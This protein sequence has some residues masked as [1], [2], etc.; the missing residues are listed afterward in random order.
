MP[1]QIICRLGRRIGRRLGEQRGLVLLESLVALV[2]LGLTASAFLGGLGTVFRAGGV[3]DER[4]TAESLAASQLEQ[5]RDTA[6]DY[7]ATAYTPTTIPAAAG[8]E[9]YTVNITATPLNSPD[10]GV[11]RLTVDIQRHGETVYTVTHF[12]VDR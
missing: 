6:Y 9:G 4:S 5:L 10:D 8:N 3:S 11:Q 2:I 12:K 7:D 1:R